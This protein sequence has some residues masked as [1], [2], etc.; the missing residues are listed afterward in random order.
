MIIVSDCQ[1]FAEFSF[2]P[3]DKMIDMCYNIIGNNIGK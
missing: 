1:E 3:I 2:S